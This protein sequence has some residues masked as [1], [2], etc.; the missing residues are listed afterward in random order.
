MKSSFYLTYEGA[1][2]EDEGALLSLD[3]VGSGSFVNS[4]FMALLLLVIYLALGE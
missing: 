3:E 2:T 4:N 1:K